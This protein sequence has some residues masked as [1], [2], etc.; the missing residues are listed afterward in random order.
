M[1]DKFWMNFQLDEEIKRKLAAIAKEEDR[2]MSA[3][4]RQMINERYDLF[5]VSIP[6]VGTISSD[7]IRFSKDIVADNSEAK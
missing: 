7:G 3:S 1:S 6:I 2:S 4:I 5:F